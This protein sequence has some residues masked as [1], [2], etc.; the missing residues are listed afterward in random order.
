MLGSQAELARLLKVSTSQPSRWLAGIE[1]PSPQ[2]ERELLD[3]DHVM[4]RVSLVWSR[5]SALAWLNGANNFLEGAR[6]IDVLL[7]RGSAD[8]INALDG[9]MAGS[10]A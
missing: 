10:F 9:E 5:K 7:T 8:V 3:L 1:T 4:A 6:P 2:H